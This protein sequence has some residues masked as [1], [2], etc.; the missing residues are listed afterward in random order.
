MSDYKKT[1]LT[2]SDG[3]PMQGNLPN[4][5]KRI[6]EY[7]SKNDVYSKIVNSKLM[8]KKELHYGPP[9]T[10]G[11][12]HI[13]H[14]LNIILKDFIA[15]YILMSTKPSKVG[16]KFRL[17]TG[18]DC[19]GLPIEVKVMEKVSQKNIYEFISECQK[20]SRDWIKIQQESFDKMG[21]LKDKEYYT[22]MDS[23][24][25]IYEAFS[26]LLLQGKIY[27]DIKP[28]MW[29]TKM[30]CVV[31]EIDVEYKEKQSTTVY[32]KMQIMKSTKEK[33][34]GKYIV[35]WTTTPWTLV[36]NGGVALH[37]EIIYQL[38]GLKTGEKV[39]IAKD[40][41]SEL[42]GKI[43]IVELL[44][45]FSG[46]ELLSYKILLEHTIKKDTLV[47]VV[48]GEHVTAENGTGFVH[49][50][51]A[52][53]EEDY[54]V[55]K[56]NN[57]PIIDSVGK[58]GFY[59]EGSTLAGLHVFND[60]EIILS[61]Y[62]DK[63]L[64]IEKITHSYPFFARSKMPII[65]I[66]TRQV[67]M[68]L[69]VDEKEL[70]DKLSKVT[71]TPKFL[72]ETFPEV[73]FKRKEWCLSRNRLYGTPI[74]V[75][76]HKKTNQLLINEEIQ[77][78]IIAK[79]REDHLYFLN[80]KC[81][82]ILGDLKNDYEAYIGVLDCWFD[83][84][85]VGRILE[86]HLGKQNQSGFRQAGIYIEGKDQT[87]GWF[88][89]SL[90]AQMISANQ[91]PY[92]SVVSHGF[93][94]AESATNPKGEKMSKSK[95]NVISLAETIKNGNE[96]L[97]LVFAKCD[98]TDD[99]IIGKTAFT[100]ASN[101]YRKFR[102]V[103]RYLIG[104][105]EETAKRTKGTVFTK[106]ENV[107]LGE[108]DIAVLSKMKSTFEEYK[109]FGDKYVINQSYVALREFVEYISSNYLNSKKD[110]LYCDKI[111]SKKRVATVYTC[112][113]L[114]EGISL[115]ACPFLPITCEEIF[116]YCKDLKLGV[117]DENKT[118]IHELDF[119]FFDS[120]E[121]HEIEKTVDNF[122]R[123]TSFVNIEA[124]ILRGNGTIKRNSDLIV[125][126]VRETYELLT[127]ETMNEIFGGAT[128]VLSGKNFVTT[129]SATACLRCHQRLGSELCTRCKKA[130]E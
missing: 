82:E 59:K 76:Y 118:S 80:E 51:P 130:T 60:E 127:L 29:C 5:D 113:K 36:D 30:E 27:L 97:R 44:D 32:L 75:F 56:K 20:Y 50:C 90:W 107:E 101:N 21:I 13:G 71:W 34:I 42:K 9:F 85:C 79:M 103:L 96:I 22:T 77:R 92:E 78:K 6:L 38:V 93:I 119:S 40:L 46:K 41:I 129:N 39:I 102:N 43:G 53:G 128:V 65:Y 4:L 70:R 47:P 16:N 3:F 83:S 64:K 94:L 125:H 57:L 116:L 99:V 121:K 73:I 117:L 12:L 24:P 74:A 114:L 105:I 14:S 1:L 33:L 19:H 17:L 54:E 112:K 52:H 37:T 124:E 2:P 10:N 72:A 95:G 28:M 26:N 25:E 68:N 7:W 89:S 63:I 31:P 110:I 18:H 122:E 48:F 84:A 35:I 98:F 115:M 58:N 123:S 100:E 126:L 111:D 49:M 67:F 81:V 106:E 11:D 88:Q 23:I 15:R 87:R 8:A 104:T 66:S 69:K 45:E 108:L 55:G 109:S 91:L 62:Q 61:K 86:K 120:I